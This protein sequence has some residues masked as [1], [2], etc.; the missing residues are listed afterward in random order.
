MPRHFP[1]KDRF[2]AYMTQE[3]IEAFCT[4]S[5]NNVGFVSGLIAEL[6][7]PTGNLARRIADLNEDVAKARSLE[8]QPDEVLEDLWRKSGQPAC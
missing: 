6:G 3:R 2:I 7:D 4:H 5:N 1:G 8:Q